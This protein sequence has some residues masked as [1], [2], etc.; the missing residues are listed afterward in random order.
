MTKRMIAA[1]LLLAFLSLGGKTFRYAPEQASRT[2]RAQS[3]V[4]QFLFAH[5]WQPYG[6]RKLTSH[7]TYEALVFARTGCERLL[8]VAPL[9][10]NDEIATLMR[11]KLG[12]DIAFL[13][14][15]AFSDRPATDRFVQRALVQS[16]LAQVGL[17]KDNVLPVLAIAPAP[18]QGG[19]AVAAP[20]DGPS[21]EAWGQLSG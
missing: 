14:D 18:K 1:I 3:A 19:A 8:Q 15:G 12:T 13:Q 5:G 6:R 10:R 4:T 7:A 21:R 9:G 2:E 16:A 20:C 11:K 17:G